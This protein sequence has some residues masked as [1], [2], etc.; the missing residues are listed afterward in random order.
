MTVCF[1]ARRGYF[2][3]VHVL[4]EGECLTSSDAKK[5]SLP[6][7]VFASGLDSYA[8]LPER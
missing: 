8:V 5:L 3:G 2:T 6:Q 4:P 1:M 7:F